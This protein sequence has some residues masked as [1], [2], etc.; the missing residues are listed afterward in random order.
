MLFCLP[1]DRLSTI[2]SVS[3]ALQTEQNFVFSNSVR[4][5]LATPLIFDE[6]SPDQAYVRI[7][8]LLQ[9]FH[10]SYL[11]DR[12]YLTLSGGERQ[13]VSL[14]SS[15]LRNVNLY[16]LDDP[17]VMM[18]SWRAEQ[19]LSILEEFFGHHEKKQCVITAVK[20]HLYDGLPSRPQTFIGYSPNASCLNELKLLLAS[21]DEM[22][23]GQFP[24][25]SLRNAE[26]APYGRTLLKTS[27]AQID[28]GAIILL[29][30]D[31]GSGKTCLLQ[32]IAGLRK[33][34]AGSI[35]YIIDHSFEIPELGKNCFYL[36]QQSANLFGF[37]KIRE[38]LNTRNAPKWWRDI[39]TLLY[40]CR[41]LSPDLRVL[42]T[43]LGEKQF[44]NL[45]GIIG[46]FA[47]QKRAVALLLDEPDA[48]LDSLRSQILVHLLHWLA[49]S[50]QFVC[51][52]T[53][54][55]ELY[56][57]VPGESKVKEIL[58]ADGELISCPS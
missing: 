13:F 5:L 58:L 57:R 17:I 26:V 47:S 40:D 20:P 29:K 14:F 7:T 3:L 24:A 30:G 44:C 38:E 42:E 10:F 55:T 8:S 52:I 9:Q 51:V 19:M 48:A 53:H 12:E 4:S 33:P 1:P 56:S 49:G 32:T 37:G 16:L 22:R 39:V 25:V 18:D 46:A 28:S 35:G 6:I 2:P 41:V 36:P 27:S 31:N 23:L 50:G 34:R 54:H 21:A 45:L 15:L 43:G 11:I